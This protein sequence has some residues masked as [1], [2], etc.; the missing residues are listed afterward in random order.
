MKPF[1]LKKSG[2]PR[3]HCNQNMTT[4]ILAVLA[5]QRLLPICATGVSHLLVVVKQL[6]TNNIYNQGG[7][8]AWRI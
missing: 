5:G 1:W 6:L 4:S 2:R 3:Q 8:A 7:F